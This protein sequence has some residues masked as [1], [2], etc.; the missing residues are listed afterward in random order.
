MWSQCR[1]YNCV[2]RELS[3]HFLFSCIQIIGLVGNSEHEATFQQQLMV[4]LFHLELSQSAFAFLHQCV[5][6][7]QSI[8]NRNWKLP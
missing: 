2:I 4:Q 7:R 1:K 3:N 5:S 8:K 6:L